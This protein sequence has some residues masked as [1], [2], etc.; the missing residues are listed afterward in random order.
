MT[1]HGT[2]NMWRLGCRCAP[3]RTVHA[4]AQRERCAARHE[5]MLAGKVTP[6]HGT[7][8]T[9]NNYHCRCQPCTDAASERERMR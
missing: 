4:Q 1:E 7:R 5:L 3:C 2:L 9:Y 8:S 6:R